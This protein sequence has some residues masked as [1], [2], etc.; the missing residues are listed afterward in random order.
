[1]IVVAMIALIAIFIRDTLLTTIAVGSLIGSLW[2]YMVGFYY[3]YGVPF[4]NYLS[5]CYESFSF[6]A[7][8]PDSLQ[9]LPTLMHYSS[10]YSIIKLLAHFNIEITSKII[11]SLVWVCIGLYFLL[12]QA[13]FSLTNYWFQKIEESKKLPFFFESICRLFHVFFVASFL[14]VPCYYA[15]LAMEYQIAYEHPGELISTIGFVALVVL[16]YYLW[17]KW[18]KLLYGGHTFQSRATTLQ[19][20]QPKAMIVIDR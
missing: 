5:G 3:L 20:R 2:L 15:L 17:G 14:A 18:E 8:Y 4:L 1:M 6:S 12:L 19:S 7:C 9:L 10:I 11:I 16:V 13:F